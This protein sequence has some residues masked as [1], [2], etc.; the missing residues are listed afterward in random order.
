MPS[1]AA[2]VVPRVLV[3]ACGALAREIRDV[4]AANGWEHIDMECL[5]AKL[6]NTPQAIPAAVEHRLQAVADLYDRILVGYADCGTGG[7]LAPIVAEYGAEMLPGAHCYEFFAGTAA[8]AELQD[9]E[10]GTFYLTDFLARHF[11]RMVW[12]TLGLDRH[13]ELLDTYFANYRRLVYLSQVDDP[14]L[15]AAAAAAAQRLGLEFEHRRAG[16]GLL[17]TELVRFAAEPGEAA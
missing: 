16:Y 17:G 7:L 8:F 13:P 15:I 10:L 5:P 14:A 2:A 11:D 3:L 4:V 12:R 9:E 1:A 6:H